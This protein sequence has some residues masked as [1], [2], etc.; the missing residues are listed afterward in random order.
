MV[1]HSRLMTVAT[2]RR[3]KI[4]ACLYAVACIAAS[5][6]LARVVV[7]AVQGVLAGLLDEDIW[8]GVRALRWQMVGSVGRVVGDVPGERII[9]EMRAQGVVVAQVVGW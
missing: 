1:T 7:V 6:R 8:V 3:A 2:A 4:L 5:G 9:Q